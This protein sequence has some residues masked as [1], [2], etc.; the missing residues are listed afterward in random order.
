MSANDVKILIKS[1]EEL[2]ACRGFDRIFP[3]SDSH[4]YF[5]YF[6]EVTYADKL[7]D[8][9][10]SAVSS[11][12]LGGCRGQTCQRCLTNDQVTLGSRKYCK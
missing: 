7:L 4:K 9:V 2:S 3:S 12:E 1:E 8:G 6:S 5:P 10:E 11:A